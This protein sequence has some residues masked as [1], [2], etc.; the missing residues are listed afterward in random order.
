MGAQSDTFFTLAGMGILFLP[1][2]ST[3]SRNTSLGYE[4]GQGKV[5]EKILQSKQCS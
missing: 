4:L 2:I 3:Q 5:L 1:A